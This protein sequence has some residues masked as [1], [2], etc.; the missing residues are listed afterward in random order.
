MVM[1]KRSLQMLVLAFVSQAFSVAVPY[2]THAGQVSPQI[3]TQIKPQPDITNCP[4]DVKC[5]LPKVITRAVLGN[6]AKCGFKGTEL[7][8]DSWS[9]LDFNGDGKVDYLVNYGKIACEKTPTYF[10][11]TRGSYHELWLSTR[12]SWRLAFSKEILGVSKAEMR[13]GKAVLTTIIHPSYCKLKEGVC[14]QQLRWTGSLV[15]ELL[16]TRRSE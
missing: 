2:V 4:T 7:P 13:D 5:E 15:E 12:F 14:Y 10:G 16:P 9:F 3:F 6:S 11:A 1:Q 8:K